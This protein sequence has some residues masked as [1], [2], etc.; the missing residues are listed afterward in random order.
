MTA[1]GVASAAAHQQRERGGQGLCPSLT[2][3]SPSQ[4]GESR[5]Y[6]PQERG[7]QGGLPMATQYKA[8]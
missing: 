1:R 7:K 5:Q 3:A 6:G 2:L 4:E 8:V